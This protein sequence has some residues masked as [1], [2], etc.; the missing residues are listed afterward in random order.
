M[1]KENIKKTTKNKNKILKE[2]IDRQKKP[3]NQ[4]KNLLSYSKTKPYKELES[5]VHFDLCK[6]VKILYTRM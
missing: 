2:N 5:D 4:V 1:Y 3:A 6:G